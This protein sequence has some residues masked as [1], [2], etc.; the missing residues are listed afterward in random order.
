M[1]QTLSHHEHSG[2]YIERHIGPAPAQQQEQL[3]AVGAQS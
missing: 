3:N 2:A 1:T